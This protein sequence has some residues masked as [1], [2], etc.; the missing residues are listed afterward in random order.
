[1]VVSVPFFAM[2]RALHPQI[3]F[4]I[5]GHPSGKGSV[6]IMK[7]VIIG[8]LLALAMAAGCAAAGADGIQACHRVTNTSS[9]T[10]QANK[11]QIELWHAETALPEVTDE[12]NGLAEAWAEEIGPTLKSAGNN[13]KKNSRLD[14]EIRYSRTGLSWMSFMVQARTLY[15]QK[16]TDQRFTTRT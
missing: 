12:I 10:T 3:D 7:R 11:S 8:V 13:G 1:M 4:A 6:H 16:L 14:V 5:M 2:P 15:H 9:L